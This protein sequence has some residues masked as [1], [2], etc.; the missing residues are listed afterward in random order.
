[1]LV[2]ADASVLV[3]AMAGLSKERLEVQR[4]LLALTGGED[5]YLLRNLTQLE[6]L[7]AAR[8]LSLHGQLT[9]REA[10]VAGGGVHRASVPPVGGHSTDGETDL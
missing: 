2:V 10:I 8:R 6:F 4:W 9:E 5:V 3:V 7:S 1:M